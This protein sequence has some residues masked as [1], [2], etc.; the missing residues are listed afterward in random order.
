MVRLWDIAYDGYNG[1]KDCT[2][3]HWHSPEAVRDFWERTYELN[4]AYEGPSMMVMK[5]RNVDNS[6]PW[7]SPVVFHDEALF[8]GGDAGSQSIDGEHQHHVKKDN[9]RVFNRAYYRD[10]YTNY[11]RLMPNFSRIHNPKNAGKC[12]EV[13]KPRP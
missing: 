2:H 8:N 13:K 4:R 10:D 9:F 12:S 11:M 5:F 1:G 6:D 3:V 7:P